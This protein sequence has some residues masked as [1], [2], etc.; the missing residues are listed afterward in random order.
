MQQGTGFVV[1]PGVVM[2]NAHVVAGT[3]K[4]TL[5]TVNGPVDADVVFY[6][7][8]HDIALLRATGELPLQRLRWPDRPA[9]AGADAVAV[10]YPLGG[11]VKA[12]PGRV[13]E[14]M[15]VA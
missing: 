11:P 10:G 2:T 12:D 7:P 6:D 5:S 4:V 3:N 13:R 8:E 9:V 15:P 1:E 14:A